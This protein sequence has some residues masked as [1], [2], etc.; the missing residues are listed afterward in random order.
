MLPS[1]GEMREN[2][3]A[4]DSNS[5]LKLRARK[6][7]VRVCSHMKAKSWLSPFGAKVAKL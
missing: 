3:T 6:K 1:S 7:R 4:K 5:N 2:V